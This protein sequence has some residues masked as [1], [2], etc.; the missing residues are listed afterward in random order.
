[1]KPMNNL[2]GVAILSS[3]ML[4]GCQTA[5][6]NQV[7]PSREPLKSARLNMELGLAY[8]NEKEYEK[9][10]SRL[11]KALKI[12]PQYSDAHSAIAILYSR[13]GQNQSASNH[14]EKAIQIAPSNS[15][16]LNNYGQHLCATGQSEKA[17]L[18][19]KRA[20]DNPLYQTPQFAF[21]NAGLCAKS[22]NDLTLAEINFRGALKRDP[23]LPPALYQ[24]AELSYKL[25]RY[26]VASQYIKRYLETGSKTPKSLWLAV[27]AAK[28]QGDRD[29]EASYALRLKN[30]FPD[31]QETRL[32][33]EMENK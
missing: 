8:M 25:Q 31:A 19:F 23:Y 16:A 14:Y 10:L 6:V 27:R 17:Q 20:L 11:Q 5:P 24:M 15:G 18:M 13:L 3:A 4:F 2:L 7:E 21:L 26:E 1:M 32:L 9:A 29:A 12:D 30:I 22:N 33:L 28:A